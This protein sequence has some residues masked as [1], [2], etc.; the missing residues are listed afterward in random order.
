MLQTEG[1]GG[2]CLVNKQLCCSPWLWQEFKRQTQT[3]TTHGHFSF[4]S[5]QA[6]LAVA[7]AADMAGRC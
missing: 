6:V 4:F 5:L 7:L 2:F 3:V 1:I